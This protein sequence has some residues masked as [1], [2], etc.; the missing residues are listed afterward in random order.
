M[1][2]RTNNRRGFLSFIG[3]YPG[4]TV[5]TITNKI[6]EECKKQ[7]FSNFY[8]TGIYSAL[9]QIHD[10]SHVLYIGYL[11]GDMQ[12]GVT[13]SCMDKESF[14]VAA[15]REITEELGIFFDNDQLKEC[16][17]GSNKGTRSYNTIY[18]LCI[19]DCKIMKPIP[20]DSESKHKGSEH[21]LWS[22]GQDNKN[23]KIGVIVY[24]SPGKLSQLIQMAQPLNSAE[25]IYYYASVPKKQAMD[26]TYV[27]KKEMEEKGIKRIKSYTYNN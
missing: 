4:I 19:D 25:Q 18:S 27:I 3:Q 16:S 21:A 9:S 11:D 13:G 22:I 20:M 7:L 23:C 8:I 17:N 12:I 2:Q 24:G 15:L 10:S 5:C 6:I 14:R 1:L 26:I